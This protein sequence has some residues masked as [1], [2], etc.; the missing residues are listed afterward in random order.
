VAS[1]V[2][3]FTKA[4]LLEVQEYVGMIKQVLRGLV[5]PPFYFRDIVEQFESLVEADQG[6]VRA[7]V[8]T[9]VPLASAE[10]LALVAA[11]ETSLHKKV[12]AEAHV[13]PAILGG[14]VVKVGDRIAD[15][16]VSR[17]LELMREQLLAA[18]VSS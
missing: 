14:V 16:S 11:L 10:T 6:V 17:M 8:T 18:T 13:D 4:A 2:I 5:T 15:R 7:R 12:R 9:A 3:D 1:G